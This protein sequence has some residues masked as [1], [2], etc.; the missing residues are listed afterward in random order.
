MKIRG[1][2]VSTNMKPERAIVKCENLTEEQKAQARQ[3]IGAIGS[4]VFYANLAAAVADLNNGTAA[5]AALES[6][7]AVE[8][9]ALDSGEK[10]VRLL[11]DVSESA[12]IDIN[13]DMT[14][15]LNGH[16]LNLTTAAAKLNFAAGT[17]CAI[18]G[19]VDGSAIKKENI[20]S[21]GNTNAVLMQGDTLCVR[22]GYYSIGGSFTKVAMFFGVAATCK[23][24]DLD[25][26]EV[27]AKNT[28]TSTTAATKCIQAQAVNTILRN[29]TLSAEVQTVAQA[30]HVVSTGNKVEVNGC[31]IFVSASTSNT[32]AAAECMNITAECVAKNS[33]FTATGYNANALE[34]KENATIDHCTI[35]AAGFTAKGAKVDAGT[36]TFK[37]SKI[38]ANA[39]GAHAQD[40]YSHS[41]GIR[42]AGTVICM[43]TDVT[44]THS[45]VQ[46]EG[47]I[48]VKGGTFSGYS[49]GGFY[50][51]HAAAH[52]AYINNAVLRF[53]VN[54]GFFEDFGSNDAENKAGRLAGF[55]F[56][57]GYDGRSPGISAYID[58]CTIEGAGGEPFVVRD[59]VAGS[60]NT[61]YISNTVNNATTDNPIRLNKGQTTNL[62]E[63]KIGMGCNFTP[64][65]TSDPQWAEETGKLYRRMK[66]DMP[67]DGRD[68]AALL[69]YAEVQNI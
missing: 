33:T 57:E 27:L 28:H 36:S 38:F 19:E 31:N 3:N 12:Q 2:T 59:A 39:H 50:F 18:N 43:D 23:V 11:A 14:L 68:F 48:Y 69:A 32:K 5:N 66:D 67:M 55:Y 8:V 40:G 21:T 20:T 41:I 47:N 22:G 7:A 10:V 65:D 24:I 51:V 53:G 15:V 63:L 25:G 49:H 44:G 17:N 26:V 35:E 45:A 46:N 56:G 30:V 6:G 34:L 52:N 54:E 62:A 1:N 42:S 29:S 16:T 64:A 13:A 9:L 58:G 37:N 4:R 61:V 60:T